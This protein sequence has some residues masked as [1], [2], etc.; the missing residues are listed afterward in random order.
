MIRLHIVVEGE[1]EKEF[2]DEV[3]TPELCPLGIIPDARCVVTSRKGGRKYSGGGI[4]R[5]YIRLKNDIMNW[6]KED[7]NADARFTMMIDLYGL[8]PDFPG[9]EESRR[10]STVQE[11]VKILERRFFE[12][13]NDY[14]LIPYIQL[15]EF[16]ALL[17]A[18]PE[19][20]AAAY[21]NRVDKIQELIKIRSQFKSPEEINEGRETAPSK[22]IK[23][24]LP[25]YEK[26]TAG[27]LIALEIG[28]E[29]LC[30]ENPHF[31][32]WIEKLKR[33]N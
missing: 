28:F 16:E 32:D 11:K 20:F 15:H 30:K 17:F 21:P 13:I 18:A 31:H 9:Y 14:R 5:S 29:K 23:T 24:I 10:Q 1:T 19:N 12:K 26:K 2:V 7:R 25:E 8:A 3:L 22:R 33:L 4:N 6:I 27:S